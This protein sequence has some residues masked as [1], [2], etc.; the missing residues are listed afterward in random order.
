M[1]VFQR[2]EQKYVLTEKEYKALFK[3]IKSHIEKDYYFQSTICNIYF[4][5]DNNEYILR[6]LE[7]PMFKEKVRLRSY[8][9]PKED[10]IVFLERKGKFKGVVFKRRVEVKLKDIYKYL[11]TGK[12]PKNNNPQ[13]MAEIDYVIK[14]DNLKPK[15]F[16]AYDRECYHDKEDQNFRITFDKNL[17]SRLENLRLEEGDAG[18]LYSKEKIYI[19]E[20]K[21]LAS[22]PMWFVKILSEC[23]I[24]PKS[25]SK[26]GNIYKQLKEEL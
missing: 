20:L 7:K 2:V 15:I 8:N 14:K 5:T 16:L 25:F 10:D 19:M 13:I 22:V 4:D 12:I 21:S 11:E 17:R 26:Y 23:K 3:K 9:V 6:S 1:H 24:Y 18:K